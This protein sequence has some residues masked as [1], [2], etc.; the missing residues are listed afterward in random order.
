AGNIL[1]SDGNP[2]PPAGEKAETYDY[3]D[4]VIELDAGLG[5]IGHFAPPSWLTDSNSDTDLGSTGPQ[6]LP[7]GL[8]FQ[9]GKNGT[10]Y[11]LDAGTLG[12]GAPPVFSSR[13]CG[14]HGSFGGDSFA[15]GVIYIPCTN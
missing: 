4:S 8:I 12:E 2:N 7:G 6:L 3:S 13:I 10:G 15:A 14:G 9:G 1:A 5:L 11:L